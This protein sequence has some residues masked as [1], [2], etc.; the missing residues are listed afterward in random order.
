MAATLFA[1]NPVSRALTV[2]LAFTELLNVAAFVALAIDSAVPLVP[3]A[4]VSGLPD[5]EVIE[6]V[7][8]KMSGWA[9]VIAVGET[10]KTNVVL[11]RK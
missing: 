11:G 6:L 2:V 5:A 7:P 4:K 1:V 9:E 3:V 8:E 10:V